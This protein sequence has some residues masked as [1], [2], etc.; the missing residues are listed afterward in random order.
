MKYVMLHTQMKEFDQNVPIIFPDKL[1]HHHVAEA[2][3]AMMLANKYAD[4]I[5]VV[6]AGFCDAFVGS[7]HGDS[8]T[9]DLESRED[10]ELIINTYQYLHGL[11]L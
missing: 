10:D 11:T 9:L 6:S 3:S 1:C 8:E 5:E 2:I 7:C 4:N